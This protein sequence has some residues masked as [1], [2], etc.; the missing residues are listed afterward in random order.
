MAFKRNSFTYVKHYLRRQLKVAHRENM[1]IGVDAG[2]VE[3]ERAATRIETLEEI[4]REF[5]VR[6]IAVKRCER[7]L[8]SFP[9][10]DLGAGRKYCSNACRQ[11]A[12]RERKP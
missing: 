4:C 6:L 8:C 10:P 9:F 3:R 1:T 12:Y 7:G 5:D 2:I 11:A